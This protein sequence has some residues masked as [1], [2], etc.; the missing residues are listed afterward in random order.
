MSSAGWL[1]L[2]REYEVL[3]L[4]MAPGGGVHLRIVGDDGEVPA[5]HVSDQFVVVDPQV[6]RSWIVAISDLGA[7]TLAPRAWLEPGF[8]ER[9]FDGEASAIEAFHRALS[10]IVGA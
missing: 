2:G 8:W 10:E 4:S 6:P 9:Y 5:L 1:T 3:A 7:L